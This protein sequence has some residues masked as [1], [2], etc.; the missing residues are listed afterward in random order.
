VRR[1]QERRG[2]RRREVGGAEESERHAGAR[3]LSFRGGCFA[4]RVVLNRA[5]GS[6][7]DNFAAQDGAKAR[8]WQKFSAPRHFPAPARG[9]RGLS[10]AANQRLIC[11]EGVLTRLMEM[12]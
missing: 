2:R 6:R 4:R 1:E 7:S 9:A 3:E 8:A 12:L 10:R 11:R 5:R